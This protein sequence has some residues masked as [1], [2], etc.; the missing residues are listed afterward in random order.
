RKS[1]TRSPNRTA[2]STKVTKA[3]RLQFKTTTVNITWSTFVP[4]ARF[5]LNPFHK[6]LEDMFNTYAVLLFT[7]HN[8]E[9]SALAKA[10]FARYNFTNY[11]EKVV[12]RRGDQNAILDT[13]LILTVLLSPP[14]G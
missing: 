10:A 1:T 13:L 2:R 6:H 11:E 12:N 8:C 5:Y 3:P 7:N 4:T 9:K 14:C